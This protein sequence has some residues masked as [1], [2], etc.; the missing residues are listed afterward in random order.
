MADNQIPNA[1]LP[2]E[3]YQKAGIQICDVNSTFNVN[4]VL[5]AVQSYTALNYIV[6]KLTG[7]DVKWF[8]AIP[9]QRAKDVIFQEYTLS[10]VEET[11]LCVK[12]VL[13]SGNFPDSKYNYDL[14]GLEFEILLE[15]HIDK[16]YWED[17]AGMGTAPQKK[18][19]VYFT[20]PNKLYQVESAYLF[21]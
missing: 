4:S 14:M 2:N 1:A 3:N 17:I 18:D 10:N 13:P 7:M 21:R 20:T 8:R 11:P 6:N 19:I 16:R 9:Q 5:S 12:V 15:I